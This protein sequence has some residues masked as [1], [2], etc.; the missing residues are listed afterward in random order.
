MKLTERTAAYTSCST[1]MDVSLIQEANDIR[2]PDM[3]TVRHN[4]GGTGRLYIYKLRR[5]VNPNHNTVGMVVAGGQLIHLV[6]DHSAVTMVSDPVRIMTIGM[7]QSGAKVFLESKGLKQKRT[8]EAA[9]DSIVVE[10]EPELTMDA[11]SSPEI[12]TFGARSDRIREITLADD[13]APITSH[14]IRKMT[15]LDHKPIGTMKVHFTFEGMPLVTFEGN[16]AIASGLD[17]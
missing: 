9:D 4:G 2:R 1:N 10:Q 5:Q 7:S 3:V 16:A 14:Y 8:G 17:P 6:P 13:V 12:E 15:G 11:I